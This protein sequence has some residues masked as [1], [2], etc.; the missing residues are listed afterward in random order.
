MNVYDISWPITPDMTAYKDK[1]T[2][3]FESVKEFDRDGVRESIIRMS[4]HSG[5]HI[6]APAHFLKQGHTISQ[7]PC[8]DTSGLCKVFDLT[9]VSDA[10]SQEHL[11]SLD[12]QEG[13]IVLFKTKNSYLLAT[14]S[15]RHDFVYVDAS[16]ARFLAD[17]KIKAVGIDYL[18]IERNQP[19]HETHITLMEN[20]VMI[21][22]G[23]RLDHVAA[24]T[25][26]LWCVPLAVVGL[27]AAPARALLIEDK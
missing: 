10:I 3:T 20:N 6:D 8:I 25:F 2:V 14:A 16:A 12:I 22:E 1:K 21:I 17:K 18:G 15:F 11:K 7:I 19:N 27:E 4:A 9:Q 13:D 26:F 24:G 5:T 23:L